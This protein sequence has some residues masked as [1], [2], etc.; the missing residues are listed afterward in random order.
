MVSEREPPGARERQRRETRE[1]LFQAAIEEFFSSGVAAARIERIVDR[2]GVARGTFYFHFPTKDHVLHELTDRTE[3]MI[4]DS[5]VLRDDAP[6]AE[7]LHTIFEQMCGALQA[8]QGDVRRELIAAQIRRPQRPGAPPAP[9]HQRLAQAILHA[10]RQ[11][12]A[13]PELDAYEASRTL[14]ASMFG[15]IALAA[16]DHAASSS[17]STLT[18]IALH[19]VLR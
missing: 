19:G 17:L 13:R 1:A 9:L 16:D 11:G 5:I 7:A 8:V 15:A 2:V 18:E 10:Q 14:L 12:L 3:A 6:L 4:A